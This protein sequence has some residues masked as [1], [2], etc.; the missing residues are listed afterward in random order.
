[1]CVTQRGRALADPVGCLVCTRGHDFPWES[2]GLILLDPL[3]FCEHQG[4]AH[5]LLLL[6]VP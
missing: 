5:T 4:C 3:S 1:M 6:S 2:S